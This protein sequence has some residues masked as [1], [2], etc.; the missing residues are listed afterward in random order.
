M[1]FLSFENFPGPLTATLSDRE[2]FLSNRPLKGAVC[3]SQYGIQFP[4]AG[5]HIS[6]SKASVW[7]SPLPPDPPM[8]PEERLGLMNQLAQDVYHSNAEIG[9]CRILPA[10][11][12]FDPGEVNL[13][14][15]LQGIWRKIDTIR[16]QLARRD[17][18]T[19]IQTLLSLLGLG[20]GLTPS[21]DDFTIGL[22]L[23]LNR[24]QSLFQPGLNLS[25]LNNKVVEAAY[26]N[27]T[28]LSANLIECATLGLADER[29]IQ[30]VDY[31]AIGKSQ[32]AEIRSGLRD[33]GNSSGI[34][35]LVG[36]ITAFLPN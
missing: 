25:V 19:M 20:S 12:G 34:D 7:D 23:S 10:L 17:L 22:L 15:Y 1:I 36:M 21:G 32:P 18:T 13:D 26:R 35:A 33:W 2:P 30:A 5:I 27:T 3:I 6:A 11:V 28:T 29:L 31:L 4:D 8:N 16:D 9:I 24:W 14:R